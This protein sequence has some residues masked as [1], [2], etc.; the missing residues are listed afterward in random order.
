MPTRMENGYYHYHE[1]YYVFLDFNFAVHDLA[2][3]NFF[4]LCDVFIVD[5]FPSKCLCSLLFNAL[6]C[7]L[8]ITPIV[9]VY[10]HILHNKNFPSMS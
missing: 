6:N 1:D 10:L 2:L 3:L 9:G 4:L 5:S 7:C 8:S